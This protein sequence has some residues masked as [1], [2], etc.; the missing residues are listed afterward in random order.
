VSPL[1]KVIHRTAKSG[2]VA[3]RMNVGIVK[4]EGESSSYVRQTDSGSSS[5]PTSGSG[6]VLDGLTLGGGETAAATT[7]V[8]SAATA[9]HGTRGGVTNTIGAAMIL[10]YVQSSNFVEL[11]CCFGLLVA[12]M[13]VEFRGIP[14]NQR[15]LPFIQLQSTGEYI[16]NQMFNET[17]EGETVPSKWK[18]NKQ[19]KGASHLTNAFFD[20][21]P[22][23]LITQKPVCC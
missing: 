9:N 2:S 15:P 22:S 14:L 18:T 12:G 23:P 3:I 10:N 20:V 21:S 4:E 19:S 16:V 6:L 11:C 5:D 17:F 13:A 7:F 1:Q 8:A